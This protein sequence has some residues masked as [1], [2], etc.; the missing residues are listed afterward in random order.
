MSQVFSDVN[1][2]PS[3]EWRCVNW[4]G[5]IMAESGRRVSNIK[6]SILLKKGWLSYVRVSLKWERVSYLHGLAH[7][8]VPLNFLF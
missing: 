1:K 7:I 2:Q 5:E 6:I 4:K 3:L 8:T